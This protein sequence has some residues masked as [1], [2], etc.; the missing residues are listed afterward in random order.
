MADTPLQ[1]AKRCY[2]AL[3][4]ERTSNGW[5][6]HCR[7]IADHMLPWKSRFMAND[8]NKGDKRGTKI[9]NPEGR[10][11]ARTAAQGLFAGTSN[12][13]RKWFGYEPFDPDMLDYAPV[14]E[15]LDDTE[16]KINLIFN[17]SNLYRTLPNVCTEI[18]TF[19]TGPFLLEEDF[20]DVVY[21]RP[22]T[23]GEYVIGQN[24]KGAV[25]QFGRE[26]ECTVENAI[27]QFGL[28]RVSQYVRE[29]YDQGNYNKTVKYFH[30]IEPN[31]GGEYSPLMGLAGNK[32]FR[33]LYWE[34]RAL[35]KSETKEIF[36]EAKGYWEFPVMCPRWDRNSGD[37]YGNGPGQDALPEVKQL[38]VLEK[39]KMQ[40]LEKANNPSM[41]APAS[42]KNERSSTLPGDLTYVPDNSSQGYKPTYMVD[43]NI[44]SLREEIM[45]K[46]RDIAEI[47]YADLF[48]MMIDS[49]RKQITAREVAEKHEEK[50][51]MLGPV[52]INLN[53]EG[54]D[55]LVIRAFNIA[56]RAKLI[57]PMP[58]ELQ[59]QPLAV[60][61]SSLLA[62]AQRLV[63]AGGIERMATFVTTLAPANPE[64]LD[65]FDFDEAVDK[66]QEVTGAP[67]GLVRPTN[68]ANEIRA[69]RAQQQEAQNQLALGA[70]AVDTA[71]TL[72]ET[73][74]GGGSALADILG[75]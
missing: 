49:D 16:N 27:G 51:L 9:L 3:K 4:N 35:D 58:R 67:V 37:V 21:S 75:I 66:Y 8:R 2:D 70:Q 60:R 46:K 45:Q 38:Q 15:W 29:Q 41:Q 32:P 26:F 47:F 44:Q 71:K 39:R 61:Y 68:K 53:G 48:R 72:S 36:A 30:L 7:E 34:E 62:Q 74:T 33:S 31:Y 24:Y 19:G 20:E 64:V 55:P 13:A 10:K 18:V 65:K 42:M 5:D 56:N 11:Q 50:L 40:R 1:R 69:G 73:G 23:F 14:K 25:N 63:D 43:P 12:P 17:R 6:A 28:E 59:G 54:F 57:K 22:F 52:L